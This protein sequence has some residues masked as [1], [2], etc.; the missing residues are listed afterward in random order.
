MR[1]QQ[2]CL[3]AIHSITLLETSASAIARAIARPSRVLVPR[4]S[5]STIALGCG[6]Y[7]VHEGD[8]SE[9]D[10]QATSIDIA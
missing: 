9:V 10:T 8:I 2:P 5:S 7:E 6:K 4:P 1:S 3:M